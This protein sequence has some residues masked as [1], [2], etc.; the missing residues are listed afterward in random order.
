MINTSKTLGTDGLMN[1]IKNYMRIRDINKAVTVGVV[2]YPNVG[3]SSVID[4]LSLK[5]S[6][7]Q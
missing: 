3:K 1:I 6:R 4:S 5:Y 2:G 7:V